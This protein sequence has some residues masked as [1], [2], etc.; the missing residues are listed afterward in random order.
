MTLTKAKI[1]ESIHTQFGYPNTKATALVKSTFEIIKDR[2]F[3]GKDFIL[4]G[5]GKFCTKDWL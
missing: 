1:A 4:K 2:L 5:L 3:S